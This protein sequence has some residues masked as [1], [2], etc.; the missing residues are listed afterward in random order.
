[1]P[2]HCNVAKPTLIPMLYFTREG[3]CRLRS[4]P[5]PHFSLGSGVGAGQAQ[6][7][8][9]SVQCDCVDVYEPLVGVTEHLCDPEAVPHG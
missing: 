8:D 4:T 1:L 9:G 7:F 5:V 3:R 6:L 2:A